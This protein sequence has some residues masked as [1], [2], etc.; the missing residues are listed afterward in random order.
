MFRRS[1]VSKG[2]PMRRL[3]ALALLPLIAAQ[4]P[5]PDKPKTPNDVVAAAAASSWRTISPD[6][7]LIMT[8]EGGAQVVIQLAPDFA[9][10]HVANIRKMATGDYWQGSTIYRVQDN[11]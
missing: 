9:P 11:Y 8:L 4:A 6:D 7:L 2:L 1:N 10:V 5:P 3:V